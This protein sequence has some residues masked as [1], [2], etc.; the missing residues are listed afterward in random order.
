VLPNLSALFI[1]AFAAG[2]SGPGLATGDG[3]YTKAQL[4]LFATPHLAN[5]TEPVTLTYD[6]RRSAAKGE[7]GFEDL[8]KMTVTEVESDGR[9]NLSFEYLSGERR[10]PFADIEGFRGNPLIMLFL[11][12]DVEEMKQ[13]TGGASVY[14]RN[15]IRHAFSNG[16][17]VGE[18][19]VE[20]GGETLG[21]TRV[22]IRPFSKDSKLD[23]FPQLTEKWYEFVLAPEV[24][25]GL[26]RIRTVVPSAA[27]G[28]PL[29]ENRLTFAGR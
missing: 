5:I 11:Q 26:Y 8:V 15:R 25:G 23:S 4:A 18:S 24:P 28:A 17:E 1:F 3:D 19:T 22:I 7:G 10:R 14:F 13:A 27:G 20:L 9:R 6:F 12:Q 2:L 29:I 16:A 21:A